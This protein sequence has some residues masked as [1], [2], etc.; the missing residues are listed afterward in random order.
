[1]L[2]FDLYITR[3]TSCDLIIDLAQG[4]RRNTHLMRLWPRTAQT[5]VCHWV[6]ISIVVEESSRL[7]YI[8]YACT[9]SL[10]LQMS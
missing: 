6:G 5:T 8:E 2:V 4:P 10:S 7:V 9:P 1:M 3:Q